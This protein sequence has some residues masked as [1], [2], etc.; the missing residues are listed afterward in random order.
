MSMPRE[1]H[2]FWQGKGRMLI[3]ALRLTVHGLEESVAQTLESASL[4]ELE[5]LQRSYCD[6]AG[7]TLGYWAA[8][9]ETPQRI[10]HALWRDSYGMG[11]ALLLAI[12]PTPPPQQGACAFLYRKFHTWDARESDSAPKGLCGRGHSHLSADQLCK[13]W[14][15]SRCQLWKHSLV[16]AMAAMKLPHVFHPTKLKMQASIVFL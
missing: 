7:V 6:V 2:H 5:S 14:G 1:R 4:L 3:C 15:G 11:A 13:S 9:E 8:G 10:W 12:L 16:C